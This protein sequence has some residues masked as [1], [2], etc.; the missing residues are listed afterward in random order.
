MLS[1]IIP[2]L[3][4]A[5]TIGRIVQFAL[6]DPNVDEVIVID[7]GSTDGT[8]ETAA[9]AGAKVQTSSMLGKGA[10]M[11]DGLLLAR[12]ELLVFMDGDLTDFSQNLISTLAEPL[13]SSR[14]DLVKGQ[15]SREAGR[16]TMLTARP[17]LEVFFPEVSW[18]VQPLGGLIA[19]RKTALAGMSFEN[20]Y[21]VDVGL[22]IDAAMG[23]LRIAQVDVGHI[24]HDSQSL[25][26]LGRMARQVTRTILQRARRHGRL[27]EKLLD[28]V[29]EIERHTESE[30]SSSLHGMHGHD[31]IVLLGLD[32]VVLRGTF[33]FEVARRHQRGREVAS[34][35]SQRGLDPEE[36]ISRLAEALAGL[37]RRQF[38]EAAREAEI[39][40]GVLETV[41][42]LRKAGRKVGVVTDAFYIGAEI[43]RRRIFADFAIAPSLHFE[44]VRNSGRVRFPSA[45]KNRRGCALHKICPSNVIWKLSA[46]L[47]VEPEQILVVGA[48]SRDLCLL[49]EAEAALSYDPLME[50]SVAG[51]ELPVSRRIEDV[52]G[53]L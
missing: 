22:L 31:P 4:E 33:A 50:D 19:A 3:N 7:D 30:L 13:L 21:G 26:R 11:H 52:L 5:P 1:V 41:R 46:A 38:E 25:E 49:R 45:F 37:E 10:S 40:P 16:V 12:N 36:R 27:D 8:P 28:E 48:P 29:W 24:T 23:G 47:D 2:V 51:Q 15:F 20:D 43:V 17:L 42:A 39:N 32:R 18:I 34:L 14:V 53:M 35:L 6:A 9:A 44:D